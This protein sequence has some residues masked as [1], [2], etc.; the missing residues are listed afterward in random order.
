LCDVYAKLDWATARHDEMQRL[1]QDFAR[2]GGGDE[3]PYGIEFHERAKPRGLVV[4]RFIV[5]TPMPVEMSLLAADLVHNTR[6]AL[7][8]VLARLKDRFGGDVRR[9][10]FP[11]WQ[12]E[13]EWHTNVVDKGTGSAL[14]GLDERAVELVYSTQPLHSPTPAEDPLV[15]LNQLDNS[16]KHRLLHQSFVYTAADRGLDLIEIVHPS[17]VR[18]QTNLWVSG[19]PLEDGTKLARFMVRGEAKGAIA[20]RSDAPIGFASGELGAQLRDTQT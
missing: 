9:G 12:S 15:I 6:V 8:H 10:S 11:T 5:E 13:E 1:F 2:P 3:R 19:Q 20:A 16:D 7:D 18:D 14:H 17:R 4:A